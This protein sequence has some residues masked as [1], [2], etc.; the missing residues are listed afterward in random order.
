[1][2]AALLSGGGAAAFAQEPEAPAPPAEI[3][4]YHDSGRWSADTRR[5]IRRARRQLARHLAD[6]R[7]ALVL[8]VDDTS[9][10]TYRCLKAAGFDREKARCGDLPPIRQTR[11]LYRYA[12][13]HGVTV[14]FVTGRRA[15]VRRATIQNLH[16][17]GYA[18]TLHVRLRPNHQAPGTYA[19]WK[20][21]TRRA[22]ERRGYTIVAN[23]GDQ[24]SDLTGGAALHAFKVPNPMYVIAKA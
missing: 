15:R 18:G 1:M 10:S 11:G 3:V 6:H 19:G 16:S 13:A 5:V 12:R 4:A 20:A 14:F 9:L 8:D 22:I 17:A 23:V 21:R 7:P 24:R 2:I